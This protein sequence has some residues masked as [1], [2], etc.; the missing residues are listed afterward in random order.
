MPGVKLLYH[1]ETLCLG[2]HSVLRH[3]GL[4]SLRLASP[5]CFWKV[6]FGIYIFHR[7]ICID[8]EKMSQISME[9]KSRFLPCKPDGFGEKDIKAM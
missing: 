9:T 3:E 8:V 7:T 6:S 1:F 4:E 5:S 2:V